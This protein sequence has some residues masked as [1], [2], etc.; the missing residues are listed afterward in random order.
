[1]VELKMWKG[2]GDKIINDKRIEIILKYNYTIL[3]FL[4]TQDLK[5]NEKA[6]ETEKQAIYIPGIS[7][8]RQTYTEY[9]LPDH[10]VIWDRTE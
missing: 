1:M 3:N 9:L 7:T 8:T 10:Q 4:H 2:R 5:K 6:N